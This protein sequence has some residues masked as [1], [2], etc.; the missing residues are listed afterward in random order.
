MKIKHIPIHFHLSLL[1]SQALLDNNFV[2]TPPVD[3][4]SLV[5]NHGFNIKFTDFHSDTLLGKILPY[6]NSFLINYLLSEQKI[7]WTLALMLALVTLY[8]Q[9]LNNEDLCTLHY[10]SLGNLNSNYF[11]NAEIFAL[12]ILIP[13]N[14]LPIEIDNQNIHSLAQ[15]FN[16]DLNITSYAIKLHSHYHAFSQA[17]KKASWLKKLHYLPSFPLDLSPFL[18]NTSLSLSFPT[19]GDNQLLATLQDREIQ[20][21]TSF[22]KQQQ[23]FA[24]AFLLGAHLFHAPINPILKVPHIP[25]DSFENLRAHAF[26]AHLLIDDSYLLSSLN[27]KK[28]AKIFGVPTDLVAFLRQGGLHV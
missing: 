9:Y 26:A 21:N 17:K 3:I 25:T 2:S 18:E 13:L 23:F 8:P 12:N 6:N 28:I 14:L 22:S 1:R 24:Q 20:I 10:S 15:Q 19:F 4:F 11:K 5:R 7:R 27:D 16:A